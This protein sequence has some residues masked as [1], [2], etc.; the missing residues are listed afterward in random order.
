M[1]KNKIYILF[2]MVIS[3]GFASC[4]DFLETVDKSNNVES[5]FF[6]NQ[7]ECEQALWGCYSILQQ[8][9]HQFIQQV[10]ESLS[11]NCHL[12][13]GTDG[14]ETWDE[15]RDNG[16]QNMY[17]RLWKK[18]LWGIHR[19][20]FL[21]EKLPDAP[22]TAEVRT[23]L[24]AETKFLRALFYLDFVR[25]FGN[26]PLSTTSEGKDLAQA[27]PKDVY[28]LIAEDLVFASEKLPNS[29][30]DEWFGR[31]TNW[32]AKSLLA[33][34]YLYYTGY[35][36]ESDL[37][38]VVNGDK[39]RT[40]IED[41]IEN[42]GHK[43]LDDFRSLWPY[44]Q[45]TYYTKEAE[46][47]YA[48]EAN[49]EVIFTIKYSDEGT[50]ESFL[51]HSFDDSFI[52]TGNTWLIYLGPRFSSDYDANKSAKAK[53]FRDGW[54]FIPVLK[55]FYDAFDANDLRKDASIVNLETEFGYSAADNQ[56]DYTGYWQ[57]KYQP[58]LDETGT[59]I[60]GNGGSAW[61]YGQSQDYYVIRFADVLLMGAEL[62][63]DTDQ[64]KAQG[65]F[66]QV[67]KRA[68]GAA[69]AEIP[70]TKD[71]IFEERRFE[72]AFEGLRYFDLLR[73][74][75]QNKLDYA[76]SRIDAKS[77]TVIRDLNEVE[78]VV[79]FRKETKGLLQIPYKQINLSKNLKQNPGWEL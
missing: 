41:V 49:D 71:N 74:D 79:N 59:P 69:Y 37:A 21:L 58:L 30:S 38:G 24:E 56:K 52:S 2:L 72:L 22:I 45:L 63:L 1:R 57:Q 64:G 54:G 12:G 48:G 14:N 36:Q 47:L 15:F 3:I 33:R 65:Y 75:G 70:V 9:N 50:G 6:T 39:V 46:S 73:Y 51:E 62:F 77:G 60:A 10:A 78:K 25:C 55:N 31:A 8:T 53:P 23:Q 4:N 27:A 20:N 76:K 35:Y 7:K 43:L 17:E 11:D 28:K 67:R 5:N 66:N 68:F 42:S 19:T 32:A 18:A 16:E 61:Q 44:S 13:A 26:V 40:Y 34:A 29:Y